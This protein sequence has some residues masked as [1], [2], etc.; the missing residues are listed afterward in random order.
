MIFSKKAQQ[1]AVQSSLCLLL[2]A[3]QSYEPFTEEEVFRGAYERNFKQTFGFAN[4]SQN[5]DFSAC[6]PDNTKNAT[7][8]EVDKYELFAD[9]MKYYEVDETLY[10]QILNNNQDNTMGKSFALLVDPGDS[11]EIIPLYMIVENEGKIRWSLQVFVDNENVAATLI[12]PDGWSM[13]TYFFVRSKAGGDYAPISSTNRCSPYGNR[14]YPVVQYQNQDKNQ[15]LMYFN[16]LVKSVSF[17]TSHTYDKYAVKESQQSSL[18]HQMRIL[19]NI[20]RP[21]NIDE[22]YETMFIACEAA[23]F[24]PNVTFTL[25]DGKRFQNLVFMVVGPKLPKVV[26]PEVGQ[27][28]LSFDKSVSSKRYM[29]EDLG[30]TSDF[31]F[32]DIVVDV[33]QQ[34]KVTLELSQERA[35]ATKPIKT[36]ISPK[37]SGEIRTEAT[38]QHLCGTKPF[39]LTVGDYAFG[40][41]TDPTNLEQTIAQLQHQEVDNPK[42]F[43]APEVVEGCD[44]KVTAII[45]DW[46]PAVNKIS[47]TVWRRGEIGPSEG[48]WTVNFPADGEIPYIMALPISQQWTMEGQRFV[49]WQKYV[50][51]TVDEH[52]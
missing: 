26:Y 28:E 18:N 38:V 23:N 15:K 44:P 47:V 24:D 1:L 25:N 9:P 21:D 20:P 34:E 5:W 7:R 32:N 50:L 40:R 33:T 6:V 4:P 41:V 45:P 8:T 27:D 10:N 16:L 13:G 37:S 42:E 29:I 3:C 17:T 43:E 19:E 51:R 22:R 35:S 30:S 11:F 36:T 48:G 2:S 46:N 14:C 39:Q 52:K 12:Y 31:D 49:D